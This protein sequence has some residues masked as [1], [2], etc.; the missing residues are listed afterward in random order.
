MVHAHHCDTHR[1]LRDIADG[2]ITRAT[3]ESAGRRRPSIK[4]RLDQETAIH[5]IRHYVHGGP[6]CFSN[7]SLATSDSRAF[8]GRVWVVSW[9]NAPAAEISAPRHPRASTSVGS[10]P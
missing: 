8:E 10:R 9:I 4:R 2:G 6:E 3:I 7:R 1:D 5:R